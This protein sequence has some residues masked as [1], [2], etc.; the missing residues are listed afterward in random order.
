MVKKYLPAHINLLS[1]ILLV[2]NMAGLV[3]KFFPEGAQKSQTV[4]KSKAEGQSD[5]FELLKERIFRLDPTW[6]GRMTF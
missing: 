1:L 6:A 2:C 5:S 3:W 4:M